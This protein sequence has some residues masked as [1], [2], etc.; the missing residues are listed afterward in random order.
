[1]LEIDL[2]NNR[3]KSCI[4]ATVRYGCDFFGH[5][6]ITWYPVY[7][8]IEGIVH[9]IFKKAWEKHFCIILPQSE[10]NQLKANIRLSLL[11]FVEK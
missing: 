7:L 3:T 1:M 9:L 4:P 10:E 8:P 6:V 11:S 5:R 2:V